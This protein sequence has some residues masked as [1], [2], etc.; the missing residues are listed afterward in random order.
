MRR[1]ARVNRARNF[2]RDTR[3]ILFTGLTDEFG[4]ITYITC[5]FEPEVLESIEPGSVSTAAAHFIHALN[6]HT[7]SLDSVT[8][9]ILSY[10]NAG[11]NGRLYGCMN[12]SSL[13]ESSGA[14]VISAGY[15]K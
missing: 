10:L 3:G 15:E 14:F 4:R 8:A 5:R 9:D 12:V 7:C 1:A 6:T 2:A 11:E 13:S